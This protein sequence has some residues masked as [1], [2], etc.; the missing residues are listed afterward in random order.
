MDSKKFFLVVAATGLI[1]CGGGDNGASE[2]QSSENNAAP[3]ATTMDGGAEVESVSAMPEPESDVTTPDP[4]S[5]WDTKLA[6][7]FK[8]E[9]PATGLE[10]GRQVYEQWCII[11]HGEGVGMA[12]TESLAR[13][14]RGLDIPALLADREDL[15]PE[16]TK[17]F[18]RTGVKS[19]P[20][21]RK[22][23]ISDEDLELLA[24][25]LA[26]EDEE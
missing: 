14:Y 4:N 23:E 6:Y 15:Y 24:E 12:G 19:M 10:R 11:C 22:T 1:A 17:M 18:V 2:S 16:T 3:T 7:G 26:P 21:F 8:A 9:S 25:Y 5:L 20:Y 13:K